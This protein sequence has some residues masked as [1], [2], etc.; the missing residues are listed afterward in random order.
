MSLDHHHLRLCTGQQLPSHRELRLDLHSPPRLFHHP[1]AHRHFLLHRHWF[2]ETGLQLTGHHRGSHGHTSIRADLVEQRGDNAAMH[3]I[4]PTLDELLRNRLEKGQQTLNLMIIA[5]V[6][7]MLLV[8]WLFAGMYSTVIESIT[9]IDAAAKRMADGDLT[10]RV[11]LNV[12]DEMKQIADSFNKMVDGFSHTVNEIITASTQVASSSSQLSQAAEQTNSNIQVQQGETHQA[13]IAMAE[14]SSTV[15][16]VATNITSTSVAANNAN[17]ETSNGQRV[18]N[19][20]VG[21]IQQLADQVDS[22]ADLVAVL[23]QDSENINTVLDVIKSIAEQTNLLALNAA[24]EAARAGEQGKGF[25]V[26]AAEVRKLAERS[27]LND[28]IEKLQSGSRTA[29]DAM[30]RSREQARSVADQA[31]LAGSSL[32]TIADAVSRIDEMSTHIATAAEEQNAVAANMN[33]N[34]DHINEMAAENAEAAKQTC[35]TGSELAAMAS[36]LSQLVQRFRV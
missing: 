33:S 4:L 18:V 34:I 22:A 31:S 7:S 5:V 27:Q 26:V 32:Q 25:A 15:R 16:D 24:I 9:A 14:M 17:D 28:I 10:T 3:H 19:E 20:V 13:A 6:G 35:Q 21:G 12:S 8:G 29:V 23:E 2:A 36:H 30:S 1:G 11:H